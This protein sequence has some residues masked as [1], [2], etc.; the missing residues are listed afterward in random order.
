MRSVTA[1]P[2]WLL[3]AA[4]VASTLC[5]CRGAGPQDLTAGAARVLQADTARVAVAARAH[6]AARLGPALQQL[7]SDVL[8]E[9]RKHLLGGARAER[10]LDA[11]SLI[12]QDA[13]APANA[14]KT[15]PTI[16]IDGNG[17][18]SDRED[19]GDEG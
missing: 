17:G 7:R 12:A 2:R 19:E 1:L 3:L 11:A 16:E 13:S 8:T 18:S 5:A 15:A 6:D 10:I 14:A 9:Q 4:L